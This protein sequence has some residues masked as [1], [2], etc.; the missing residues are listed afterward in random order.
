[1]RLMFVAAA[2]KI[3]AALALWPW[4]SAAAPL[5]PSALPSWYYVVLLL[6]FGVSGALLYF[7]GKS[8]TRAR[9]LGIVFLLFG[10]LFADRLVARAAPSF[11]GPP[12]VGLSFLE[13]IHLYAFEPLVLWHFAWSFPRVQSALVPAWFPRLM[14]RLALAAA[15]VLVLGT[16]TIDGLGAR[17]PA[18]GRIGTWLSPNADDGWFWQISS[19]LILP[20]LALLVAKLRAANAGERRRLGWVVAGIVIGSVP[21]VVHVLLMTAVPPYAGF[22]GDPLRS[23]TLGIVLTAFSLVIPATTAYAVVVAQILE[24]RFIVR[25]A[26]QY[27]LARY[28]VLGLMVALAVGLIAVGYGNRKRPLGEILGDSP[29]TAVALVLVAVVFFWRRSLLEAIDRRF[30]REQYD[31]HG[32]LVD[33]VDRSQK[34]HTA[35]DIM[36]LIT[37]EVDRALHLERISLLLR[38]DESDQLRDP[39]GRVRG[40]D[41]DG[42]L[43][44]LIAGSPAPLDVDLS[45]DSSPL[46]RLP[47]AERE[48]LADASARLIVP[49]LGAQGRPLGVL[50]LGDKR[51]EL[52]FT[53]E[54]RQL[55]T[56]VAAS[57]ALALERKLQRES[58]NPDIPP[59]VRVH[60]ARQCVTCGRVQDRQQSACR[61]CGGALHEALLPAVLAGKFEIE[62]QIG[63]GGMG[64]VYRARDLTLS[65]P[66]A[67]KVLP[68][69]GSQATAR[70]RREAR[71]MATMQ[72]QH[73]AVIHAMESWRGAPVLVLEYLA[74]GTVADRIRGGSLPVADVVALGVVI[75]DVLHHI[76]RAG[77]LHRDV[78][79]SNIG[80]TG[81]G[82]AKLL[83]FGL[84]RLVTRL[85]DLSATSR[86][87]ATADPRPDVAEQPS[88]P[89][90]PSLETAVN[91]LVGTPAYLSPEAV[92]MASPSESVDLWGLA[93][94]LYEA[95][96]RRNPFLAPTVA[97]IVSLIARAAVPDP[98]EMRPDCPPAL[99]RFFTSA[100]AAD[101]NL[102]PQ[103]A[104]DFRGRLQAAGSGPGHDRGNLSP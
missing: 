74:G 19:I 99:A 97:E 24:V 91:R 22:F 54:D 82:V 83:D 66:V 79:P 42:A 95:L 76:H 4:I 39:E 46:G 75:A 86:T 58:P 52:P 28:T 45:S 93:V 72:H 62:R 49:L 53:Q 13:S 78:K 61:A 9:A 56:A 2:V 32:I 44:S 30:F 18:L 36:T 14:S 16:A 60:A 77:Y 7:G 89:G 27:A 81:E 41:V 21:M 64:V 51:S 73:L 6:I 80:Y 47:E 88:G 31:A 71:T 23:R 67:I 87:T 68:R 102:R 103:S 101:H 40:L 57:A 43:G 48:W 38:D 1:M 70:L 10:T 90:S 26:V 65:R 5:P 50:I 25:R 33:L 15:S 94:T 11:Q 3:A 84:V 96:T 59:P 69:V 17:W 85:S 37:S 12:G 20:S 55:M 98:R 92:A 100:L 35:R 29:V 63:A 8:D 34:A 104:L